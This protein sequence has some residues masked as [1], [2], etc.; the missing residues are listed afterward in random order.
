MTSRQLALQRLLQD[1]YED[2]M[3]LMPCA[4]TYA[5]AGLYAYEKREELRAMELLRQCYDLAAREGR[6]YWMLEACVFWGN[7]CS[8]LGQTETMMERYR[9]A[10]R[11]ARALGENELIL[12]LNYNVAATQLTLGDVR[13]AWRYFSCLEEPDRMDLHKLAVCQERL[14]MKEEA[15]KTVHLAYGRESNLPED[16]SRRML[17]VV[18]YR[19]THPDFLHD[20]DYMELLECCMKE[21]E[22]MPKGFAQ[23]H[24]PELIAC[25][26]AN[27]RY[28]D[29]MR[30]MRDFP[31]Q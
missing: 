30:L 26:S 29:A 24:A 31:P 5:E 1:R 9:I 17:E 27:R 23:F 16:V 4:F 10:R 19:L 25:Y 21:L 15:L 12:K 8:D 13:S 28:K 2:A 20:P 18:E 3:A 22:P 11:L 14:G 7:V 6:A